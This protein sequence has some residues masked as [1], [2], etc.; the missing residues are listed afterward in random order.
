MRPKKSK[1]NQSYAESNYFSQRH[2]FW[3]QFIVPKPRLPKEDDKQRWV[4]RKFIPPSYKNMI[5]KHNEAICKTLY[6]IGDNFEE[7]PM[8]PDKTIIY[9]PGGSGKT[10]IINLFFNTICAAIGMSSLTSGRWICKA[11][12]KDTEPAKIWLKLNTFC[13]REE[14]SLY[15]PY[16]II[17]LDNV[18]ELAPS[19]QQIL[20]K[21]METNEGLIKFI[22]VC[23]EPKKLIGHLQNRA[24]TLRTYSMKEKDALELILK[25]CRTEKIGFERE[26][27]HEMFRNQTSVHLSALIDAVQDVFINL[28]YISVENILKRKNKESNAA[29]M[30]EVLS[31]EAVQP[32]ARCD[33]CTLFP[34]CKHISIDDL[35]EAGELR[36]KE[37]PRYKGG[38]ICPEFLAR[39]RCTV[40]NRYGHCSLDHSGEL[41]RIVRPPRRC[42]T[43]TILWP[44][45][46]CSFTENRESVVRLIADIRGRLSRLQKFTASN[47]TKALQSMLAEKDPNYELVLFPIRDVFA[48]NIPKM[49]VLQNVSEWIDS[50]LCVFGPTYV[51]KEVLLRQHFDVL[52]QCDILMDS[53]QVL[54]R[55]RDSFEVVDED[56]NGDEGPT[57]TALVDDVNIVELPNQ[58]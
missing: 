56:E 30:I 38:M 51:S 5:G 33:I 25:I 43:C 35:S 42:P 28:H 3:R 45:K 6:D 50:E 36:R 19:A 23:T 55:K 44:C 41:H 13:A 58:S 14:T 18:D 15:T 1:K 7:N 21:I 32:V 49:T 54:Q 16:R 8:L 22:F 9:G 4:G 31:S 39:G 57:D 24:F 17:F 26:G 40:F 52:L 2:K 48:N 20:K 37:L 29:Q 12:C 10:T 11:D 34:P 46:H 53:N 27:I 47:P